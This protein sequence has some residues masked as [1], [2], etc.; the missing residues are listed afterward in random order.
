M[1]LEVPFIAFI[2]H[3]KAIINGQMINE[4]SLIE[5]NNLNLQVIEELGLVLISSTGKS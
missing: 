4:G 3:G 2:T 5:G 1:T